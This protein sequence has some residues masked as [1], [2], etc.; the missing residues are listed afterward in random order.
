MSKVCKT[1]AEAE[2]TLTWYR[3]H[4]ATEGH[5]V[6]RDG[7]F[8]VYRTSDGKVLK[9]I[10]YSPADLKSILEAGR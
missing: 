2:D 9:S 8:L 10:N 4:K 6:E 7:A 1:R 3:D 5:I